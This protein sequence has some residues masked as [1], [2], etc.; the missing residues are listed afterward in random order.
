VESRRVF[1]P[2]VIEMLC[3]LVLQAEEHAFILTG[4]DGRVVWISPGATRLFAENKDAQLVGRHLHDIFTERDRAAGIDQLEFQIAESEAISEDDR[5]HV[6][7]D[8]S[9]FWSSGAMVPLRNEAGALLGFGK[10]IRDRTDLKTQIELQRNQL[11]Q[12]AR[13]VRTM[14][15][16]IT[17]LTHE[18]RN[19]V[20]GMR[21]T[22]EI[23]NAPLD[24]EEL[25]AKFA[26]LMR[27]Q[28][29]MIERFADDLLEVKRAESGAVSLRLEPLP[30]HAELRAVLDGYERRLRER[31]VTAQLHTPSAAVVVN[32]DRQRLQQVFGNLIDNAIKYTP[33]GGRIWVKLTTEDEFAVVHIEDT[34]VGI[35]HQMLH[36]IF[37]LFTQV[38]PQRS[39]GLGVGLAL[40][41]ELVILHGGSV[42]AVSK[43]I[44]EG[45]QFSVRLPLLAVESAT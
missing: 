41:R 12:Q 32:A 28:L 2:F 45:S 26:G 1:D 4:P 40:V 20:A 5:W 37:E 6:R 35:P 23:L 27:R 24:R 11:E 39:S 30:L 8:G 19:A 7:A 25:R 16:A 17:K 33:P 38:D 3:H 42:Q 43:G 14:G 18:L 22:V 13:Q 34:G 44:D 15:H 9:S 29:E 10:I 36:H 21:G 31:R